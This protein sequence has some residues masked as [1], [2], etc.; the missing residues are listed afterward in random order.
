M[1]K[2]KIIIIGGGISGLVVADAMA[3]DFDVVLLEANDRFGG[4]MHTCNLPGFSQQ[5][6]A[7]AEFIHGQGSETLHLLKRAGLQFEPAAGK[8]YRKEKNKWQQQWEMMEGWDALMEKMGGLSIDTTLL[9]FLNRY[10]N[11]PSQAA[12][13]KH[14]IAFAEG[15]D[16]ADPARVSVQSLY[17]EWSKDE[18][19]FRIP[20]GYGL[21]IDFLCEQAKLKG[22]SL[23]TGKTVGEIIWKPG[24][25][26]VVTSA[27]EK[28]T[29]TKIIVTVPLPVLQVKDGET[30]IKFTPAIGEY[31]EASQ[32]IGMGAV[33]KVV[34]E[35]KK[36]LWLEDA[37]F[38]LSDELIPTWW[39]QLPINTPLLTGWAGGPRAYQ[40]S[41]DSDEV[42]IE[43]SFQ[44]LAAIFDLPVEGIKE[45][46]KAIRI[47][48][49]QKNKWSHGAYSYNT[50][51]SSQAK[52]LLN[53]PIDNTLFFAGEALYN[54]KS[55]GTVEA[56]IVSAREVI[57][58]IVA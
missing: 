19:N 51:D 18:E 15:F 6:E 7:G 8:F 14:I 32:A 35:F 22:A 39:T 27:Y 23:L 40:L 42:L 9:D 28:Y 47:F 5:V 17:S 4:R 49:W 55:P 48:N 24:D 26:T 34:V 57:K 31:I 44:S 56:A 12:M 10:Y 43:K 25:S 54:G 16:V 58:K 33:I 11:Q 45:Q 53:T 41:T 38:I 2:E 21:L 50:P 20:G 13:R 3:S 36:S 1:Q 29:A 46:V 52:E 37:G 30:F